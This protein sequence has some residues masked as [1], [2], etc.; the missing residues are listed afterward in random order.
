MSGK[1]NLMTISNRSEWDRLM[2]ECREAAFQQT[3]EYGESVKKCIAW[4]PLRQL[5]LHEDRPV[6]ITQTLVREVP[7]VGWVARM[8]HGP[9]FMDKNGQFSQQTAIESI[10][11]LRHH[12]V[13]EKRMILHLTPCLL[14]SDLPEGWSEKIGLIPSD[15]PL[16]MSIRINITQEPD[17][18]LKKMKKDWKKSL[19]KI[20]KH[21][22]E[23]ELCNKDSDF[24]FFLDN[25]RQSAIEKGISWPSAELV[26]ELWNEAGSLMQLM[27]VIK[28]KE[29]IAGMLVLAYASTVHC[30]VSWSTPEAAKFRAYNFLNWELILHFQNLG[31]RWLDMGGID[32][33]NL[34]GITAFKRGIGGE[35]YQLIGNFEAR[36]PGMEKLNYREELGHVI[37][38][39]KLPLEERVKSVIARF[40]NERIDSERSLIDSG[41]IDSLTLVNVIQVIQESFGID[42]GVQDITIDN[43]DTVRGI[44]EL[45]KLRIEN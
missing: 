15:E 2:G 43:F 26:Q 16:W 31:Y 22:L 34:P 41:L 9:M 33:E 10:E 11:F 29:R 39:L 20:E 14:P 40:T 4:D 32:P 30:L 42:I 27:F 5:I 35:E 38:G 44:T 3:W 18:L 1:F 13:D 24:D 37:T 6:A 36:P 19:R 28:N 7:L 21:S 45:I 8:Q 23:T 25:Y 12:W 17:I